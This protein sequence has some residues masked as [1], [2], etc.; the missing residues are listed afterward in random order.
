M[1]TIG[2]EIKTV[3]ECAADM[4]PD[5]AWVSY[6]HP[7]Y[8]FYSVTFRYGSA[9]FTESRFFSPAQIQ[10]LRMLGLLEDEIVIGW[11]QKNPANKTDL[12]RAGIKMSQAEIAE[13]LEAL[14]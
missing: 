5:A 12:T 4:A 9:T 11:S 8:R 10:E 3:P 1:V 6:I 7:E 13:N 2:Q 14:L